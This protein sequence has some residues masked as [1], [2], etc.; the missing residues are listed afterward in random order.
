MNSGV[1]PAGK[2]SSPAGGSSPSAA[3]ATPP[4]VESTVPTGCSPEVRTR[5]CTEQPPAPG[6]AATTSDESAV[7]PFLGTGL[8]LWMPSGLVGFSSRW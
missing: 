3:H 8:D 1:R 4:S 6:A 7:T 5:S 2:R